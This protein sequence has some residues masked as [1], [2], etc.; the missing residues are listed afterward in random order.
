M[1]GKGMREDPFGSIAE[2]TQKM[3]LDNYLRETTGTASS[4]LQIS[5]VEATLRFLQDATP[6]LI[7]L[8]GGEPDRNWQPQPYAVH[9]ATAALG[10]VVPPQRAEPVAPAPQPAQRRRRRWLSVPKW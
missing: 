4:F 7:Q 9:L 3:A 8:G 10:P 5:T 2:H 1:K 6:R